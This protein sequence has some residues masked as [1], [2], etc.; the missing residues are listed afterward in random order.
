M[1]VVGLVSEPGWGAGQSG[2]WPPGA[3]SLVGWRDANQ[4]LRAIMVPGAELLGR[5]RPGAMIGSSMGEAALG[6][7]SGL[8]F[9]RGT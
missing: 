6:G 2:T 3:D 1:Q 5:A 9:L 4:G 7:C 8:G